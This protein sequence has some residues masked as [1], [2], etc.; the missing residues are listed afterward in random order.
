LRI[1]HKITSLAYALEERFHINIDKERLK[2]LQLPVGSW[3]RNLKE[4]IWTGQPDDATVRIGSDKEP[5]SAPAEMTLGQLKREIVRINRGQKIVYVSDCRGTAKNFSKII[6]FASGADIL[7]CE[8]AFLDKDADKA[9]AKGHLTARQAGQI[10]REAGVRQLRI[11]HFSP[12]Y[13][14]CPGLLFQE[15]QQE[16]S[17][18]ASHSRRQLHSGNRSAS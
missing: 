5:D 17:G 15:A 3:L 8:A 12:R 13:E 1:D 10:A 4:F 6:P 7:F 14:H 9:R 11:F 2:Q 16:F 18:Q